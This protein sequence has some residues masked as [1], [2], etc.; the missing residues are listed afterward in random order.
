MANI[1]I[2][3][4]LSG[5]QL[6]ELESH[7]AQDVAQAFD[8]ARKHQ[9]AW[10]ALGAKARARVISQLHDELLAA[11]DEM[12]DILQRETGKS[13]SHAFE[14]VAGALGAI[15]YY[16]KIS[17]RALKRKRA[18]AGVPLLLSA[19]VD[20]VP[21]GAVG[22]ITPWNYPLALTMMDVVPALA[23]GNAVVQKAD[24]Q[25]AL[26][27]RFAAELAAR[28][29]VPDGVWQVVH[30]DA[31]EVGNA[32]TDNADYIAFTGSTNTGRV[33]AER[34]AKRLI[35]YSL[36]LGGK[37]PMIILP[38][39]AIGEACEQVIAGAFGNAG[40]LCVSI[41]RVYVPK[42][43]IA[44]F[45]AELKKRIESLSIGSTPEFDT[46]L[47]S[48]SSAAQLRR[49]ADTVTK[50]IGDGARLVTGGTPLPEIGPHFYAPTVLTGIDPGA[51]LLR[52]EVFGPV[53]ALVG[54]ETLDEAIRLANDSEYG[55][56]ASVIGD[57]REAL[58]VAGQL[59]AGS[60]N[61]NEGYRA[62][63]ASLAAP[64]G[65]MKASGTDRRSGVGGLL[66]FT[67]SR[68]I[69][70]AKKGPLRL[71]TRGSHYKTMAPLMNRL[72]RV[73]KRLG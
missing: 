50:A 5:N 39:A 54:Y 53:V 58:G 48:L 43:M 49:V 64:M 34:A 3:D 12:M 66:R 4:P 28:A 10:G 36:E 63:M 22:V 25:T 68:T 45:E 42:F 32:V 26:T 60:V 19:Y 69:G 51:T 13:R 61:I 44:E 40:Q 38:S 11:S 20:H 52:D 33:V 6:H 17:P 1:S 8:T 7:S 47:G 59:M 15:R 56:N 41:E 24:N 67:E 62:S 21:V 30:G 31:Q 71:P 9:V 29:G 18:R 2:L 37:N 23:A 70:I 35:G 72:A 57:E 65:G 73:M 55:L 16:A 46:D 14:E 27:T